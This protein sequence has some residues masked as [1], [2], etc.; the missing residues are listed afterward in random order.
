MKRVWKIAARVSTML[1]I[2]WL[3]AFLL[4]A[5]R[6]VLTDPWVYNSVDIM[7]LGVPTALANQ[8]WL[9]SL[10]M[11]PEALILLALA[12]YTQKESNKMVLVIVLAIGFVISAAIALLAGFGFAIILMNISWNVDASM[13]LMATSFYLVL[14][15]YVICKQICRKTCNRD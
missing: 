1:L 12:F 10:V 8:F 11:L 9:A 4:P 15:I 13:S 5:L 7:T 2:P 14:L 6:P 3:V